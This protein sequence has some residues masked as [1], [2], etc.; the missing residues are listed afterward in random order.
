MAKSPAAEDGS[1][2][3]HTT[4]LRAAATLLVLREHNQ[5]LQVLMVKRAASLAFASNAWVFPGGGLDATDYDAH[6][7]QEAP[8]L[9]KD[10]RAHRVAALREAF[11]ETGLLLATTAAA[12]EHFQCQSNWSAQRAKLRADTRCFAPWL[13]AQNLRLALSSLRPFSRWI[14]PADAPRRYD[15]RF[16]LA[17]VDP[18]LPWQQQNL[19]P[20]GEETV[21]LDWVNPKEMLQN[22]HKG[23]VHMIFPTFM[24]LSRLSRA[25]SYAQACAQVQE[26]G[27][28][29][30]Q[31][32]VQK[33]AGTDY[34]CIPKDVGYPITQIPLSQA[35][36]A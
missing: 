29:T 12:A 35:L 19:Q 16:Y 32:W 10:E 25:N 5:Q 21:A 13:A 28:A 9:S 31:P 3:A 34:L 27:A 33:I 36:R 7:Q 8:A 23:S 30:I 1:S 2:I 24:N 22:Y 20:D 26:D 6:W 17:S 15:T 18:D 4:L 11:E 14:P